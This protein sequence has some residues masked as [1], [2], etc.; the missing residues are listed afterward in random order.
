[1]VPAD[2]PKSLGYS[3]FATKQMH[4]IFEADKDIHS[5]L[6]LSPNGR[7]ILYSQADDVN[8]HVILVYHYR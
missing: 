4:A 8:S 2:A 6:S 7:R 5:N 1:L 3:D